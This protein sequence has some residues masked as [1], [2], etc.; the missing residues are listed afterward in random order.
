MPIGNLFKK[1]IKVVTHDS[2]F[3]ADD[4]FATAT[5]NI[6]HN[7]NIKIMRSRDPKIIASGDIVLDVGNIYD[8]KTNRFDHHQKGGAGTRPEGILLSSFGLIWKHFGRR[9]VSSDEAWEKIDQKLVKQIDADD[10]GY[11]RFVSEELGDHTWAFDRILKTFNQ[12]DFADK[13]KQRR[14]FI[15]CVD[16]ATN[17]L[18]KYIERTESKIEDAKIVEQIYQESEDKRIIVLD[19]FRSWQ[20]TI[21][22]KP[23]PVY[24]ITKDAGSGEHRIHAVPIEEGGL[25][26]RKPFP[27]SWRGK[28]DEELQKETGIAGAVFCHNSGFMA[29]A[30]D[31]DSAIEMSQKSLEM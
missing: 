31:L 16:F 1:K 28:N 7:G 29:V 19:K 4:I 20:S 6:L 13:E 8:P 11:C 23:E 17:F 2:T 18:L 15:Y 26:N 12:L 10:T 21:V 30:K 27:K 22:P 25:E 9:L 3:H 14:Q 5:L 24:L